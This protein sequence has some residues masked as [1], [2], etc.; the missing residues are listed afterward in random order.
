MQRRKL[1]VNGPLAILGLSLTSAKAN[2]DV[3]AISLEHLILQ[4]YPGLRRN[5]K[6][7]IYDKMEAEDLRKMPHG[8]NSIA[9]NIWH[10]AR[11]ED[12]G[13]NRLVADY[14]QV[15]DTGNYQE[16]LKIGIRHFG[17]GMSTGESKA[18]S[19]S[20]NLDALREYHE[21]VGEQTLKVL[22]ELDRIELDVKLDKNHLH[23]VMIDEG[24][25]HENALWVEEF[26]QTKN[27][28][29]FLAHMALTH[30]FE[31]L[32]QLMLIRKLLG[33]AGTR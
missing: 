26:Y 25:L 3:D 22:S 23:K 18:L 9:W 29:W 7:A 28:S 6:S 20:I 31:H 11:A 13:L 14:P 12:V 8:M 24:V 16:R 21:K 30:S 17:T 10:M 19:D 15:F 2:S 5:I 32:G 1:L 33:Y 27:R 4:R